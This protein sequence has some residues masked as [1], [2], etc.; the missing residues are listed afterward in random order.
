M[1]HCDGMK[2]LIEQGHILVRDE[3]IDGK[4]LVTTYNAYGYCRNYMIN[5]CPCCGERIGNVIMPKKG[6][7]RCHR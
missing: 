4:G 6:W 2:A 5:H 1:K 3:D 7:V